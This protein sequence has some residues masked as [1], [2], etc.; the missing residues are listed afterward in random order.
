MTVADGAEEAGVSSHDNVRP[1]IC[2]GDRSVSRGDGR[3]GEATE[4]SNRSPMSLAIEGIMNRAHEIHRAHGGLIG[5]YLEDWLEAEHELF[6]K[7]RPEHFQ[8]EETVHKEPLP[9]GQE[10]NS[11]K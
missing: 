9:R 4:M 6:E 1:H 8:P 7:N 11:Q 3:R 10:R 5:Y 2:V